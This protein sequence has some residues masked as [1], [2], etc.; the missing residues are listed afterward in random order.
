MYGGVGCALGEPAATLQIVIG[1]LARINYHA[2][3]DRTSIKT[4]N[5]THPCEHIFLYA[6][7]VR[8]AILPLVDTTLGEP[9]LSTPHKLQNGRYVLCLCRAQTISTILHK[10]PRRA[11]L[12]DKTK[13]PRLFQTPN[14]TPLFVTQN[15]PKNPPKTCRKAKISFFNF[16]LSIFC[17][18]L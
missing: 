2:I 1:T 18:L 13:L 6:P 15:T 10:T 11:K 3:G 9:A 12:S 5:S 16:Q 7:S 8:V 14:F 4:Q 17:V